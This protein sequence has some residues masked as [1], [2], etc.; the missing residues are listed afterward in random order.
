[1]EF[2]MLIPQ[3]H[4]WVYQVLRNFFVVVYFV[5][6][7]AWPLF[8]RPAVYTSQ[9]AGHIMKGLAQAFIGSTS[10]AFH[11]AM[12]ALIRSRLDKAAKLTITNG[13]Q[14]R[15]STKTSIATINCL[16]QSCLSD[17]SCNRCKGCIQITRRKSKG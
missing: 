1:M 3:N 12:L 6:K 14:Q 11:L 9:S 4:N 7:K 2:D 10:T 5:G 16:M 15:Q 13:A 17:E 8:L